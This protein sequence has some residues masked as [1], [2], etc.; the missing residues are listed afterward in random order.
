MHYKFMTIAITNKCRNCV[1]HPRVFYKNGGGFT[2]EAWQNQF[3]CISPDYPWGAHFWNGFRTFMATNYLPVKMHYVGVDAFVPGWFTMP[4]TFSKSAAEAPKSDLN[5]GSSKKYPCF[6]LSFVYNKPH[7]RNV[8]IHQALLL[9]KHWMVHES[10]LE[11]LA[12]A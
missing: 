2:L 1:V 6:I 5:P 10:W 9:L 11:F 8:C 7:Y 12:R 4:M 3:G